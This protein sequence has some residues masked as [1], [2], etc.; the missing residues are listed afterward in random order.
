MGIAL[1]LFQVFSMLMYIIDTEVG[2]VKVRT[3]C[4]LQFSSIVLTILA[5]ILHARCVLGKP[6]NYIFWALL[7]VN[8]VVALIADNTFLKGTYKLGFDVVFKIISI[9]LL[10]YFL[11]SNCAA[12]KTTKGKNDI[13]LNSLTAPRR[14]HR[15]TIEESP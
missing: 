10:I 12:G 8:S 13:E 6:Q 14:A 3:C 7:L 4:A 11:V 1:V 5:V 2:D 9:G 15:I